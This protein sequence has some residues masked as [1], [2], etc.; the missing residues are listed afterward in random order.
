MIDFRYHIVSLIAVFLALAI[1]I[2]LGAGP[3]RESIG[4]Q[5]AQQIEDLR[6]EREDLR[7][8]LT[9]V[10]ARLESQNTYLD[11]AAPDL[12]DGALAGRN[13]TVVEMPGA[14]TG[15]TEAA[16]ER[17]EQAGGT[18]VGRVAL[19]GGWTDADAE[20]DREQ[21]VEQVRG[22]MLPPPAADASTTAALG[23]ALAQALGRAE[24][25]EPA[26]LAPESVEIL[27]AMT[28]ADV[29]T[30]TDD[31]TAPADAV[32]VVAPAHTAPDD[33]TTAAAARALQLQLET[34]SALATVDPVVLGVRVDG[35]NLVTA[36]RDDDGVAA[37]VSTVDSADQIT[38]QVSVPLA[39]A[40]ADA[41]LV[42][43][44]GLAPDA[45]AVLPRLV[46]RDEEP[47]GTDPE[48]GDGTTPDDATSS[49]TATP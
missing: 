36:V 1:G 34:V 9:S 33:G 16:Q 23:E 28:D 12:L 6:S 15:V 26:A 10:Q 4:D 20:P 37:A 46:T 44:Y 35:T 8:D 2:V 40:A 30:R 13:V 49:E 24:P 25:A 3:L 19:T 22:A 17:I 41:G 39:L 43:Q 42:G 48:T 29:I 47:T 11:A 18:L 38:G 14:P 45:T 7:S 27:D 31:V 5:L 21:L 32:L